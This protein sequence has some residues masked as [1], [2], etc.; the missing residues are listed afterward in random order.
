MTHRPI[1]SAPDRETGKFEPGSGR[2][3]KNRARGPATG[4]GAREWGNATFPLAAHF[5]RVT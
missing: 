1:Y 4:D 3:L 2:R 5:H